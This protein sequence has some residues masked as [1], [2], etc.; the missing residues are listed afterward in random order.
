MS[1]KDFFQEPE[2][3]KYIKYE[4]VSEVEDV[5]NFMCKPE[6]IDKMIMSCG[7][8]RPALEGII[9]DIELNFPISTNFDIDKD[10]T[11]RKALGSMIKYI[12]SD[13]GYEVNIQK[14]ISKGSHIKSATHYNFNQ[15]KAKKKLVRVITIENI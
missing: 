5:F 2:N 14:D 7:Q 3:R 4:N 15:A 9:E 1:Y 8:N 6:S 12:I 13:F 10:Y 11:L